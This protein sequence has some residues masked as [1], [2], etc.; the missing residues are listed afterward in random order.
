M[1]SEN[2]FENWQSLEILNVFCTLTVKLVFSKTQTLFKK[3]EYPFFVEGTKIENTT[4]PY[5]TALSE[6][7]FKTNRMQI[8]KWPYNKEWSLLLYFSENFVS[9]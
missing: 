9:V 7:N 8:A 2:C 6:A 3:L 1:G 4:F 5:K